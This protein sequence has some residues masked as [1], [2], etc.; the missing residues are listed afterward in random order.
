[1]TAYMYNNTRLP[2]VQQLLFLIIMCNSRIMVENCVTRTTQQMAKFADAS[3]VCAMPYTEKTC[4]ITLNI[5]RCFASYKITG[6]P[7]KK[8]II[9][10]TLAS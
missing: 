4:K 5:E 8:A 2:S 7:E 1:M 6:C 9:K 10:K 3:F